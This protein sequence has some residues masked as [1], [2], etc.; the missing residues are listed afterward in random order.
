MANGRCR[1]HGGIYKA[2]PHPV[3]QHAWRGR[4]KAQA[5]RKAAGLPWYGGRPP[6]RQKV[7]S[8]MAKALEQGELALAVLE[9]AV[10]VVVAGGENAL[11]A[12]HLGALDGI[13]LQRSIVQAVQ[14]EL[15]A[16]GIGEADIKLLRL[17]NEAASVMERLCMRVAETELNQRKT[18]AI[19]QLIAAL[20]AEKAGKTKAKAKK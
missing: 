16:K 12:L 10:P 6:G 7:V 18:G 20:A 1:N 9:E 15:D 5:A 13:R 11:Q 4:A 19:E 14:A 2:N 17:G 3:V 8:R